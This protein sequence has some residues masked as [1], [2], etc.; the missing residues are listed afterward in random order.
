LSVAVWL[1]GT[2]FLLSRLWPGGLDT[3]TT[4]VIVVAAYYFAA[5][6]LAL[7]R[8]GTRMRI[9]VVS[10]II[11]LNSLGLYAFLRMSRSG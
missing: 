1:Y 9:L 2:H 3:L 10:V 11:L 7:G 4:L 5:S 8:T 6:L